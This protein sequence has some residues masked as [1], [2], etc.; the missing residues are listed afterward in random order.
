MLKSKVHISIQVSYIAL[1]QT[2]IPDITQHRHI[3]NKKNENN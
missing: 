2:L 3:D 1:A